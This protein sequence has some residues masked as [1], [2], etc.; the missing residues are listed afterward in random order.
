MNSY[1]RIY[2]I[3]VEHQ[4]K[5]GKK[6]SW[7]AKVLRSTTTSPRQK[8]HQELDAD[9]TSTLNSHARIA[10][11][12]EAKRGEAWR[13][14]MKKVSKDAWTDV[15]EKVR[16]QQAAETNKKWKEAKKKST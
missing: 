15:E 8:S 11:E 2:N 12:P 14:H 5:R 9:I 13:G 4:F 10:S 1:E 16:R 6:K 3:L 7:W